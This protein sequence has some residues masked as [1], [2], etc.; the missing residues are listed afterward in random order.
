MATYTFNAELYDNPLTEKEGDFT[1]RPTVNTSLRNKEIAERIVEKR[2]EYRLET[3]IN[4]LDLADQEKGIAIAQGVSVIDG[5]GQYLVNIRGV[6]DSATDKFD[7]KRHSLGV[8]YNPGKVVRDLLANT[9][10][11]VTKAATTGPVIGKV[12][13]AKSNTTNDQLTPS[14]PIKIIGSNIKIQ[15]DPAT[16]GIFFVK[17]A[18]KTITPSPLIVTNLPSELTAMVPSLAAGLYRVRVVTNYANGSK[19]TKEARTADFPVLLTVG[20]GESESPDVV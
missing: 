8:S 7:P 9:G 12:F 2:T 6:F 14:Q 4:I 19:Q 13:D 16:A 1:A 5:V 3:I 15:G 10:V 17:D 18:D 20:G 11:N